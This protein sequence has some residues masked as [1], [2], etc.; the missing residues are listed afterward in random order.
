VP[1]FVGLNPA[2]LVL[3]IVST[4]LGLVT[5]GY[6]KSTY[7]KWSKIPLATGLSGAQVARRILDSQGLSQVDIAQVGGNLTDN[8]DPRVDRL[9]LS[10]GVY[11]NQSVA[12]AGVAAHESGHALQHA[13]GYVWGSIRS[14]LVPVASFGSMASWVLILVGIVISAS[15]LIYLGI[16]FYGAAVLFQVVTLPVEFDASR[17]ALVQLETVGGLPSEQV[18]GARQV[19]TAAA[20][21]YVAAALIAALQLLYYLLLARD[22]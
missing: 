15:G 6:V 19:L 7:R 2:W 22:R 14:A 17:R 21:T 3:M 16:I 8:Y 11:S 1:L 10:Q 20:L 9:S 18:A 5:Q 12:A 4:L 13:Q